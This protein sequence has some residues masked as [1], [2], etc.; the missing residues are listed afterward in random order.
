LADRVLSAMARPVNV[1]DEVLSFGCSIGIAY[2]D[3]S[4][5]PLTVLLSEADAAMYKAKALG[6]PGHILH[7]MA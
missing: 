6:R 1:G 2:S 4:Q 5:P 7:A 3:S